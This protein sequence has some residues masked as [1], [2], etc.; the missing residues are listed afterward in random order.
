MAAPLAH[1]L[2]CFNYQGNCHNS[3]NIKSSEINLCAAYI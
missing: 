1:F 2:N 3:W